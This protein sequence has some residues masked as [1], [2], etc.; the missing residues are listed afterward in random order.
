M[1]DIVYIVKTERSPYKKRLD[2]IYTTLEA[3]IK[4]AEEVWEELFI[5]DSRE[6]SEFEIAIHKYTLNQRLNQKGTFERWV[7]SKYESVRLDEKLE[8]Y[9]IDMD[10]E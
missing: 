4:V 5:P 2:G 6:Y 7:W 1:K 10:D 9:V 8:R 3:A